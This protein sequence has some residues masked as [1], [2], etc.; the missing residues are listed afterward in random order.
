MLLAVIGV[1]GV[2]HSL[3]GRPPLQTIARWSAWLLLFWSVLFNLLASINAHASVDYMK[4]NFLINLGRAN[5]AIESFRTASTLEPSDAGFHYA[6]ANALSKAGQT[7]ESIVQYQIAL[8]MKP[9]YPEAN[10]NLAFTLL[11]AGRVDEAIKYFQ[12]TLELQKS[13]Q[14]FYNLGYAYRMNR[15]PL[16]AETN[17]QKAIEL[18][19]QFILAQIDLSWTLAT[20][21]DATARDG[22]R[23]LAIAEN[24]NRQRPDD[25]N[26]LRTLAA[27]CAETGH[28]PEAVTTA[29][30]AL[31]LAR[32]QS[33]TTLAS[34]LQAET[35]LYESSNP[36]R[37]DR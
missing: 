29:K 13:Y 1:F 8:E 35:K 17:L 4:G 37:S 11:Q 20:S 14:A 30:R 36:C 18:Q 3:S 31:D 34:Q 33:R 21:P 27:A 12:K 5:E 10:N 26:I 32:N 2:N 16:E 9:N 15:M 7:D 19:P 23:A 25:P 6:L 22:A 24:L 28:F